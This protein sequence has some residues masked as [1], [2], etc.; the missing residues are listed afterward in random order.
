MRHS[1]H[2]GHSFTDVKE[3]GIFQRNVLINKIE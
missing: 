2:G 1:E 3:Y